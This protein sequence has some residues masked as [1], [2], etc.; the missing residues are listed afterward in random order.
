MPGHGDGD[1]GGEDGVEGVHK[2]DAAEDDAAHEEDAR[3]LREAANEAGAD[4][5]PED[6]YG[7]G[8]HGVRDEEE[9]G[10]GEGDGPDEAEG[11]G[12]GE[13]DAEGEFALALPGAVEEAGAEA[14]AGDGGGG[15]DPGA[16]VAVDAE[17]LGVEEA[18]QGDGAAEFDG[19][20]D[21][22]GGDVEGAGSDG[23][24]GDGLGHRAGISA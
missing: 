16:G 7:V 2:G 12:E 17:G 13:V 18:G 19:R 10:G 5:D 6:P 21:E 14:E 11:L 9:G 24:L 20:L 15:G 1:S 22:V 23:A 3:G 8:G 4:H